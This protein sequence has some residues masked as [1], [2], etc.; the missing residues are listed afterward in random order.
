M[1]SQCHL[2]I[3][4][5][6]IEGITQNIDSIKNSL[7]L[8]LSDFVSEPLKSAHHVLINKNGFNADNLD[9]VQCDILKLDSQ[10]MLKYDKYD[11][12]GISGVLHCIPGSMNEKLPIIITNLSNVMDKNTILFGMTFCTPENNSFSIAKYFL[13]S[14]QAQK[15]NDFFQDLVRI[16]NEHFENCD[17][18]Q[19]G[20]VAQFEVSGFKQSKYTGL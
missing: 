20:F 19:F 8:T 4:C 14:I 2:E 17:I 3:G 15:K 10:N 12:I 18:K 5:A 1:G 7:K 11:T 6:S 16:F 13:K 9:L